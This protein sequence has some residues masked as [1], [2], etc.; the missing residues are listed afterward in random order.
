MDKGST[1]APCAGV[2]PFHKGLPDPTPTLTCCPKPPVSMGTQLFPF[3][4]INF[5]LDTLQARQSSSRQP[6]HGQAG[7]NYLLP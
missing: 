2:S 1:K 5:H 7:E 3:L 4:D 6:K